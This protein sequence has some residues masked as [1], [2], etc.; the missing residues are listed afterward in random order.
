MSGL[1]PSPAFLPQTES[2]DVDSGANAACRAKRYSHA[3]IAVSE[4]FLRD[5]GIVRTRAS[6]ELDRRP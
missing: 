4:A 3:S 1:M 6:L 2:R 5:P